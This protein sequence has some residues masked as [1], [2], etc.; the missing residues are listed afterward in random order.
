MCSVTNATNTG[1]LPHDVVIAQALIELS[2][3]I[4]ISPPNPFLLR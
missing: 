3:A 1:L 4:S 2:P